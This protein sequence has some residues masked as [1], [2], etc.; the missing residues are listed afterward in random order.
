MDQVRVAV[1]AVDPVT[2]AGV[3]D[4]LGRGS[5]PGVAVVGG[6]GP[7]RVDVLVAAFDRLS[8]RAVGVLRER[9]AELGRP[10]VLLVDEIREVELLAAVECR[11]VAI[12]PRAAATDDRLLQAVESA[13][14]AGGQVPRDLLGRLLVQADQLKRGAVTSD[15]GSA[16]SL[17]PREVDVLRLMADGLDT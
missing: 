4:C 3:V 1:C 10:V 11:V 6:S 16:S 12:L 9:V 5:G 13:A 17:L 14:A 15:G 7:D 2:V 8:S